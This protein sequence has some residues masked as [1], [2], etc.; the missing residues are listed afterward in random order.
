MSSAIR[1]YTIN[2]KNALKAYFQRL[3]WE[4]IDRLYPVRVYLS[5]LPSSTC[6]KRTDS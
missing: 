3:P 5:P 6:V 2:E 1:P 4:I